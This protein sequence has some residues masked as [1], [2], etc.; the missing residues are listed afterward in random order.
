MCKHMR[1]SGEEFMS[2]SLLR[3]AAHAWECTASGCR[4][5]SMC[6]PAMPKL[7][8]AGAILRVTP[9]LDQGS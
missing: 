3:H 2:S 6:S 1:Q 4:G 5:T 7:V 8:V 9:D